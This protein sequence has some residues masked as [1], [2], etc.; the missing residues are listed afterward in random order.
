MTIDLTLS[1][2]LIKTLKLLK[3]SR[4]V[5]TYKINETALPL[6]IPVCCSIPFGIV[7]LITVMA[8]A[9][10]FNSIKIL[11]IVNFRGLPG[12]FTTESCIVIVLTTPVT[13]LPKSW[14]LLRIVSQTTLVTFRTFI[15]T[16]F[17]ISPC[18]CDITS[19]SCFTGV[20]LHSVYI[21][22]QFY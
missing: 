16:C 14:A 22:R 11:F 10:Y 2:S 3:C 15:V 5:F 19:P 17:T 8:F 20:Q 13:S 21:F 18:W 9:L 6:K 12:S 4:S 7:I 1:E